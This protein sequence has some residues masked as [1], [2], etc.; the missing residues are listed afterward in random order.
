MAQDTDVQARRNALIL[1][2]AQALYSSTTVILIATG[3]LV[4]LMLAPAP[5]WATL[6]ISA[7]VIGTMLMTI[8]ASFLM[9]RFGRVPGFIA[10]AAAG[11]AGALLAIAAIWMQSFALFCAAAMLQGVFQAFSQYFR[12]AAADAASEA[13]RP[14]AISWV[15]TGGI[16][17]AVFGTLIV[18]QTSEWLAPLT[19]AGCYVMSAILAVATAIT[20]SF[21]NIPKPSAASVA[22]ENRPW[23]ELL[24]QPRLVAAMASATLAYA[25][26]NLMMTATPI[27][28][29]F[30]G[31][32]QK[33]SS[34]VIQWH[35]LAMFVPSFFTGSI[36][37]R[38]GAAP[39]CL[40]GA[41]VLALAGVVSLMGIGFMHFAAA[42]VLLGLGWNF[43]F[44]GGTAM[45][46]ESYK[47]AERAK[48]Q[49]AND[50]CISAAMAV[51]SLSSGKLLG[52]FG[53]HSV[54]LALFPM[55][56]LAMAMLLWGGSRKALAA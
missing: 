45:L 17:A 27:A 34:W 56:A 18:I 31:F 30:C 15:M 55:A 51:A 54:A 22:G 28:M 21:L 37:K 47:P 11:L 25:M 12:F 41:A 9:R 33:Q 16:V 8:P 26:M 7:F 32:D 19:F 3:G 36:I 38:F 48:V 4:G 42:L 49:A 40:A 50:F 43:G 39:V 6:P 44:I 46:T 10:G 52:S 24:R 29:K 1:A 5:E 2:A 20:V 14:K 53:W 23:A 13:F 35:V